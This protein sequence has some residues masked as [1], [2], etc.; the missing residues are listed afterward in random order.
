MQAAAA[1]I[2]H[3]LPPL[4]AVLVGTVLP[5]AHSPLFC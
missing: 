3:G 4:R 1:A 5:G 2:G